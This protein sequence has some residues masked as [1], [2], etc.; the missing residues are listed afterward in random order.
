MLKMYI[1]NQII[2][3]NIYFRIL[4]K[5][6]YLIL[7][8][9]YRQWLS[10]HWINLYSPLFYA[11]WHDEMLAPPPPKKEEISRPPHSLTESRAF[12]V[13]AVVDLIIPDVA[14]F[15]LLQAISAI[16]Y[17]GNRESIK[18]NFKRYIYIW[19]SLMDFDKKGSSKQLHFV[20]SDV[21][22]LRIE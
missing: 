18:V 4:C 12:W 15:M 13:H 9:Y 1:F 2:Y 19:L 8:S 6:K 11:F 10:S 16:F 3:I 14:L 20:L 17:R 5:M 7:L 22:K 21:K